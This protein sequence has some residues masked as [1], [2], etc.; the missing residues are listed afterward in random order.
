MGRKIVAISVGKNLPQ[1][2]GT[3]LTK[4]GVIA[5]RD[6]SEVIE[7]EWTSDFSW[8]SRKSYFLGNLDIIKCLLQ[9]KPH[10]FYC[11]SRMFP[12]IWLA[13]IMAKLFNIY[14]ITT[15][16]ASHHMT[17]GKQWQ[18]VSGKIRLFLLK[19]VCRKA[20]LLIA[21]SSITKRI[22]VDE[23]GIRA[24]K[25]KIIWPGF[26]PINVFEIQ[27]CRN[28][29]KND[30]KLKILCVGRYSWRKGVDILL[31]AFGK[32]VSTDYKA[33]IVGDR[34]YDSDG[35]EFWKLLLSLVD[36]SKV[37]LRNK[38]HKNELN[39]LYLWADIV[40]VPSRYEAFGIVVLEA[41]YNSA[42]VIASDALPKEI[43]SASDS[44]F[45]FKNGD[46]EDL[47]FKIQ[48]ISSLV[49]ERRENKN[50]PLIDA[51]KWNWSRFRSEFSQTVL[52][53]IQE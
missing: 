15:L 35:K 48:K 39:K 33:I 1:T 37:E 2:G 25:I 6:I 43:I 31:K 44:I 11:D 9:E 7:K 24:E 5:L 12:I 47:A 50:E 40:V 3:R 23:Y 29:E 46:D 49:Y 41:L 53:F 20:D 14:F 26:E 13:V 27:N 42:V 18:N 36:E 32:L 28:E 4:E 17:G 8:A 30:K 52:S 21:N 19:L 45:C 22:A 10:A 16:Q 38:V 34:L 51:E